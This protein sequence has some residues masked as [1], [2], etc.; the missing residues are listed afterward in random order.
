MAELG[1]PKST[2]YRWRA[3]LNQGRLEDRSSGINVWNQLTPE[4]ASVVLQVAMEQTDLSSR[5]L[6]TWITD[7]SGFSVSES[8]VYRI[9]RREGWSRAPR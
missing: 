4:E 5:Q 8:T 6:A 1:V 2:Y 7:H 3:R 9:L